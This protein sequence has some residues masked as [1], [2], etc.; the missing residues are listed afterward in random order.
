MNKK[1]KVELLVNKVNHKPQE[2]RWGQAY[3]KQ[4]ERKSHSSL[5]GGI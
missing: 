3:F 5:V 1:E 2:W 4:I